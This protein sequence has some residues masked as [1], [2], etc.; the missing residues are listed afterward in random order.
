MTGVS[1]NAPDLWNSFPGA[2]KTDC[3][4]GSN[5]DDMSTIPADWGG[6]GP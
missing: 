2:S 5:F 3:F 6:N 4:K 1:G